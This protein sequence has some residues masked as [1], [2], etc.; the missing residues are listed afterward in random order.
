M[1][2]VKRRSRVVLQVR[3]RGIHGLNPGIIRHLVLAL[4]YKR[5]LEV[6]PRGGF[7]PQGLLQ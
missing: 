1:V 3:M 4:V 7:G 6:L 2:G 5:R